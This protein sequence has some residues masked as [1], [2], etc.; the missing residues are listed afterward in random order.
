M[1]TFAASTRVTA[2]RTAVRSVRVAALP[3]R[4]NRVAQFAG[5]AVVTLG[6]TLSANAATIKLGGDDG[7]LAFVP[8]ITTISSGETVE[9]KCASLSTVAD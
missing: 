7:S 8:A 3:E 2:P 9:F 6:L 1:S 5:A 4:I